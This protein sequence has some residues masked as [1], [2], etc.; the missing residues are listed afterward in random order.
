LRMRLG[1]TKARHEDGEEVAR[2]C[3]AIRPAHA[4]TNERAQSQHQWVLPLGA[5]VSYGAVWLEES[6]RTAELMVEE[7]LSRILSL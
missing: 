6:Y 7:R 2:P 4:R 1:H 5:K 3:L